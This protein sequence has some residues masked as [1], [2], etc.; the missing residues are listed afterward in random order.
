MVERSISNSLR[1]FTTIEYLSFSLRPL[2][3]EARG[4]VARGMEEDPDLYIELPELVADMKYLG[5]FRHRRLV[6]EDVT[7]TNP[8]L[9]LDLEQGIPRLRTQQEPSFLSRILTGIIQ[10]LLISDIQVKKGRVTDG[11]M[12]LLW[13]GRELRVQGLHARVAEQKTIVS[14]RTELVSPSEDIRLDSARVHIT[15]PGVL[16]VTGTELSAEIRIRDAVLESPYLSSADMD[17]GARLSY[18]HTRK[19]IRLA[20]L[21]VQMTALFPFGQAENPVDL[22]MEVEGFVDL[23]QEDLQASRLYVSIPD[24]AS[25]R[26]SGNGALGPEPVVNFALGEGRLV[27]QNALVFLPEN[28]QKDLPGVPSG[29]VAVTGKIHGEKKKRWQWTCDLDTRL[30]ENEILLAGKDILFESLLSGTIRIRGPVPGVS[31]HSEITGKQTELQGDTWGLDP[32]GWRL[33]LDG[34]YPSFRIPAFE[35]R[36]PQAR[37]SVGG[38]DQTIENLHVQVKDGDIQLQEQSVSFP[39]IRLDSDLLKNLTLNATLRGPE[40][41]LKAKGQEVGLTQCLRGMGLDYAGQYARKE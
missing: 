4:V 18:N 38:R 37:L 32:F 26:G 27:P 23:E 22:T 24:L 20:S 10:S 34:T 2:K 8:S 6:L 16:T 5:P 25:I 21:R 41:R 17:L 33:T 39:N 12:R 7:I 1:G 19:E 14:C 28:L 11:G 29:A 40:I 9:R 3:I 35:A 15:V 36:I 31:V 30:T 13:K